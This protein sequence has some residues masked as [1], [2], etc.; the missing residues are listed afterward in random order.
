MSKATI[1]ED[2]SLGFKL[3]KRGDRNLEVS[4]YY[5]PNVWISTGTRDKKKAVENIKSRLSLSFR[6]PVRKKNITLSE[7]ADKFFLRRDPD[8]FRVKNENFNKIFEESYYTSHQGRLENYILPRF[9]TY[10]LDCITDVEVESWYAG[11]RL[12]SGKKAADGTKIK[13]LDTLATVLEFARKQ[14]FIKTNPLGSVERM[15]VIQKDR[16]PFSE[17][18]IKRLSPHSRE[19]ILKIWGTLQWAVFFSIMIDTGWR[20]GEVSAIR[21]QDIRYGGIYSECS[22]DYATRKV[23]HRI[24]TTGKGQSYKVGILSD[25]TLDL[26]DDY[27]AEMDKGEEYLFKIQ[28]SGKLNTPNVSNKHLKE[29]LK[30]A[31]IPDL[32]RTQHCFR[33]SFDTYMLNNVSENI[34]MKDVLELMA[35]TG[36]QPTY[37]HRL[38]DDIILR[39]NKVKP[40]MNSRRTA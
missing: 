19:D 18:E 8:S 17:D 39:L 5:R 38:P 24:K 29:S 35:H 27:L 1:Y 7:Y 14:G 20:C 22:V 30:R 34:A 40:K 21:R 2:P 32:G 15:K 16:I 10:R 3:R 23:K 4:Y 13:V 31:G 26:L 33:H 36:Y 9:G 6:S 37:D 11:L 12:T 25:Y 28:P